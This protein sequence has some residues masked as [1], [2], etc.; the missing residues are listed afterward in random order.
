MFQTTMRLTWFAAA[1]VMVSFLS[2]QPLKAQS[3][4]KFTV[5]QYGLRETYFD[6]NSVVLGVPCSTRLKFIC[7][8]DNKGTTGYLSMEFTIAPS[9]KIPGFDF[10]YFEGPD[11]PAGG[12][13][14]MTITLTQ[15]GRQ[16][17]FQ[18]GLGGWFSAEVDDGFVFGSGTPTR[19]KTGYMRK[20][21]E[22][23]LGGAESIEVAVSDGNDPSKVIVVTFPVATGK[24]SFQALMQGIK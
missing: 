7:T 23:I 5:N 18:G 8:Q 6:G 12:K 9:S 24:P 3:P 19:T 17:K 11:A 13:K 21:V 10:E 15:G 14:L 4:W 1:A 16:T 20:V 22:G 2:L